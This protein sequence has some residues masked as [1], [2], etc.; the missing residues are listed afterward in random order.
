MV[1]YKHDWKIGG[2]PAMKI[3]FRS[4]RT[5]LVIV[6]ATL[7]VLVAAVITVDAVLSANRIHAGIS[8]SGYAVGRMTREQATAAVEAQVAKAQQSQITV[9]DGAQSWPVMPTDLGVHMDVT[10]AVNAA[11]SI[12]R[13]ANVFTDLITRFG[14]YFQ[15]RTVALEGTVDA[16]SLGQL[17]DTIARAID[18][19]PVNAGLKI[20]AGEIVVVESKDGRAV[21]REAMRAS[22]ENLLLTLHATELAVPVKVVEPAIKPTDTSDAVAIA[23]T[24]LSAPVTLTNG[25]K[26]WSLSKIQLEATL[27]F[28][29]QATAGDASKLRLVPLIS[30]QKT[31]VFL[32]DVAAGVKKAG[33]DAKWKLDG[34][35]V[36]VVPSEPA[37]EIDVE[38]TLDAIN[39]AA[40]SATNRMAKVA[41]KEVQPALTTEKA[42]ERGIEVLLGTF[43][44]DNH[45]DWGRMQNVIK[46]SGLVNGMMLAPGQEF[47]YNAVVN[48]HTDEPGFWYLAPAIQAD[49][50]LK[51]EPGGGICQVSTTLFNSVFFAGL[52]VLERYNHSNYISSY[53]LGRD[54]TVSVNGPNFRFRNDMD[55]W[56]WIRAYAD[57]AV[58]TFSIYGKDEG[59]KVSYTTSDWTIGSTGRSVTVVRIVTEAGQTIHKDVFN[60]FFPYRTTTTSSTTTTTKPGTTT[61]TKPGSTT[62][63]THTPTTT[64]TTTTTPPPTTT[65]T[66]AP[67]TTTGT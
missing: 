56:V 59:R 13:S 19:E 32:A 45:G 10:A 58:C 57:E 34:E 29:V 1:S 25:S 35:K 64:T 36:V 2:I 51:N 55:H 47:D 16:A 24:I 21:D 62:S 43:T 3:S 60:S 61:T 5:W 67:P 40:L 65:T 39:V 27:D 7:V 33:K 30:R 4:W 17:V 46:A 11:M 37:T 63:T 6:C 26:S 14:L 49:G 54:A 23:K 20:D 22:L 53:P 18:V 15:P 28:T 41:L 66:A 50:T 42:K 38:G 52:E 44:T 48:S 12:T 8:I 31:A 9:K